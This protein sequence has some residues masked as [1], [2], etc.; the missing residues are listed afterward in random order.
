VRRT[1]RS[2]QNL[3]PVASSRAMQWLPVVF[4][5]DVSELSDKVTNRDEDK[6]TDKETERTGKT[7][8]LEHRSAL[9]QQTFVFA[10]LN[11]EVRCSRASV[12]KRSGIESIPRGDASLRRFCT[13]R[14]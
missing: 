8:R 12:P 11:E 14:H 5:E 9:S 7:R 13:V 10:T 4:L 6:E 3:S 1:G 2:A